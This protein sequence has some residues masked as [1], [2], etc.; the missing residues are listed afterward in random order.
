MPKVEQKEG[1]LQ[2]SPTGME[3][4]FEFVGGLVPSVIQGVE[5]KRKST[6]ENQ[7][8]MEDIL[9]RRRKFLAL[10]PDLQEQMKTSQPELV[11]GLFDDSRLAKLSGKKLHPGYQPR[12]PP[13]RKRT[14]T[15]QA[16]FD[17][18]EADAKAAKYGAETAESTSKVTKTVNDY[19]LEQFKN[20]TSAVAD[21]FAKT[22]KNPSNIE[23]LGAWLATDDEAKSSFR[24]NIV[25]SV[26]Y[27]TAERDKEVQTLIREY[28]PRT[29]KEIDQIKAAADYIHG[30][31]TSLPAALPPS[32]E[33]K[34][35]ELEKR[36]VAVSEATLGV[37]REQLALA[38]GKAHVD[39]VQALQADGVDPK[40]AN[41]IATVALEKGSLPDEVTLPK[42]KKEALQIQV[43]E[44][45]LLV[46]KAKLEEAAIMNPQVQILLQTMRAK[47][48]Y[49]SITDST[50]DIAKELEHLYKVAKLDFTPVKANPGR[51]ARFVQMLKG[52]VTTKPVGTGATAK[53]T[54]LPDMGKGLTPELLTTA[55][56][57]IDNWN[58][59]L[60]TQTDDAM[61]VRVTE[62]LKRLEAALRSQNEAEIR[63]ILME[64]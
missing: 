50:P 24:K 57:T 39:L 64:M 36:R 4:L 62:K 59:L 31:S 58:A 42:G 13:T 22:G 17:K 6:I 32:L 47:L 10:D 40:Q 9:E 8:V 21:F 55:S 52:G 63:K 49:G 37:S 11:Q 5:K 30:L 43:E 45:K 33:A 23:E 1:Y 27:K 35:H 53:P 14:P 26:E 60:R 29:Q 46:E 41:Q 2:V 54:P 28:Q 38:R 16:E 3:K 61:Q 48:S 18:K 44:A 19:R 56:Q 51:W 34:K 12:V 25:G 20:P 7:N 15:E